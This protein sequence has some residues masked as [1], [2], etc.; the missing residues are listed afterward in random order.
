MN[1]ISY[2][3]EFVEVYKDLLIY[4]NPSQWAPR[5]KYIIED[6]KSISAQSSINIP[7]LVLS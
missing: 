3:I 2:Q 4:C 5:V 1:I 7:K 6:Y